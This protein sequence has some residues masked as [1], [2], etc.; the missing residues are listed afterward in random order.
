MSVLS[1][2]FLIKR[3]P[4]CVN[5]WKADACAVLTTPA[6]FFLFTSLFS[7]LL[8]Q[9]NKASEEKKVIY[10]GFCVTAHLP[11]PYITILP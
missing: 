11:L 6:I 10:L 8:R 1:F 5:N 2:F 7:F 4:S 9:G 3:A